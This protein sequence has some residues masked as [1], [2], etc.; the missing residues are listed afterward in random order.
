MTT[1]SG[2]E[3]P[4]G[5][6]TFLFTDVE[7]SSG[8]WETQPQLM[9]QAMARH[10]ALL[11]SIVEHHDGV[12][13]RPRGEGDSLFCVF[14]RATDAVAAAL[15]GQ[16]ALAAEDWGDIG[17]LKVRMGLHTGEAD[18]RDGDYYGS[19]VNRCARIRGAGHGGQVLLSQTT[20]DLVRTGLPAAVA[21]V[22]LGRH[23]LRGLAEPELIYQLAAPDLPDS[24][25]PLTTLDA[26]PNNLPRSLTSFIGRERE[27]AELTTVLAT[28]SLVTLTGPGGSGKTRLALA[29]AAEALD[30]F[31]DGVW[32][33]DLSGVA[34]PAG[35]VPAIAEVLGVR[36]SDG[37]SLAVSLAAYLRRKQ[38]L[39]VVD[40]FEQVVDA[41]LVLYDLLIEAPALRLLVTSREL[42]RLEGERAFPVPPLPLP[43]A[44]ATVDLAQL[45]HNPAVQLFVERAR[46]VRPDF[47]LTGA[48]AATV[49]ALCERLDGLPLAIELA[50]AR[51]RT[52]SPAALL[53]RLEQ[54]LALL[55]G[56]ERNRPDRQQTLRATISWSWELLSP[57]EQTLFRRLGV[58]AGGWTLDAAEAVCNGTGELDV[59]G[60]LATLV[61]KSLVQQREAGAGESRFS[62][63][64][65]LREF[66]LEQP[67]GQE[68]TA[69]LQQQ[70][71]QYY[72]T[73]AEAADAAWWH[74]GRSL[75]DLFG[76][77]DSER[78]NLRTALGWAVAASDAAVGLRLVGALGYWFVQREPGEG[79]RWAARVL[80]LPGAEHDSRGRALLSAGICAVAQGQAQAAT[81]VFAEAVAALRVGED[82]PGLSR[83]LA[84]LA[85]N[86]PA[87][88]V[89]QAQAC[90]AEAQALARTVGGDHLHGYV[91]LTAGVAMLNHAGDLAVARAHM[92][93]ALRLA[94]ALGAEMLEARG[95]SFSAQLAEAQGRSVEA[96]HLWRQARPLLEQLGLRVGLA[97]AA[98]NLARLAH[99]A[100]DALAAI[101]EWRRALVL[102]RDLGNLLVTG[103][104]LVDLA[105]LCTERG[106]AAR[107]ARLLGAVV[108]G[109]HLAAAS[110]YAGRQFAAASVRAEAAAR[111]ELGEAAFAQAW[112]EGEALSLEQATDLALAALAD[113]TVPAEGDPATSA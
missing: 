63:L 100:G 1:W 32:F 113:L 6:L 66:A 78:E 14:I 30:A 83:A 98:M 23:R 82:L 54:R 87:T 46:A 5:T 26:R 39:L 40:N 81:A 95:L 71:A 28:A 105:Q 61:D 13:V 92:D 47:S 3:L 57:A 76:L 65:T 60:G 70:H 25:P 108:G 12:V 10:D 80:A 27:L 84:A 64:V 56:G 91:E 102:A 34:D 8:P 107:A 75:R 2:P 112:A 48:N 79:R 104:C 97:F 74:S 62:M 42:L 59:L 38:L 96:A 69:D 31:S 4:T 67:A 51:V 99:A 15:A 22:D 111:A 77:L 85:R 24:F 36:E 21:L 110:E 49:V 11:T 101:G 68:E 106:E 41:A 94:R 88:E 29:V 43:E 90:I 33:V 93:T 16:R 53:A 58:F 50:A 18:V 44:A 55:V 7:G 89:T 17:S 103:G 72:C 37:R 35:V 86:L 19:A 9:R 20:A 45:G 52:L 109:R 73:L